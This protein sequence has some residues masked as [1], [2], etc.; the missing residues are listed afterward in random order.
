MLAHADNPNVTEVAAALKVDAVLEGSVF[1]AGDVMRINVQLTD[2]GSLRHIW[3]QTYEQNVSN[4]LA[5]QDSV[6]SQITAEIGAALAGQ[7]E[8]GAGTSQQE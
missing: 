8:N 2:P 1:R 3:S 5:A 7:G 6:V 4:V